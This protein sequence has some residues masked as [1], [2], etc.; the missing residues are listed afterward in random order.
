MRNALIYC[1]GFICIVLLITMPVLI[2]YNEITFDKIYFINKWIELLCEGIIIA[3]LFY[4][5]IKIHTNIKEKQEDNSSITE[6]INIMTEIKSI[7]DNT[8]ISG[9]T[10]LDYK[11]T[12]FTHIPVRMYNRKKRTSLQSIINTSDFIQ[13]KSQLNNLNSATKYNN[14]SNNLS[15][16]IVKLKKI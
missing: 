10:L 11:I 6:M 12:L 13:I 16:I 9:F 5:I 8:D 15:N 1:F 7:V 2:W 4:L 14:L 3:S